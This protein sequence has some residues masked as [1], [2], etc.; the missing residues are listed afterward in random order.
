MIAAKS[1]KRTLL[2]ADGSFETKFEVHQHPVR[3]RGSQDANLKLP[4]A[5]QPLS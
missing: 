4:E 3:C 5:R 1:Y 2:R